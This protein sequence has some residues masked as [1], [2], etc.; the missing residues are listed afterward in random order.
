MTAV[1]PLGSTVARLCYKSSL[2][3]NGEITAS[4]FKL[5]LGSDQR[6]A[7]T[8]LSVHWLEYLGSG[9]LAAKLALLREYLLNSPIEGE[10][11]PPPTGRLAVLECDGAAVTIDAA[12]LATVEFQHVPRAPN[13]APGTAPDE[14]GSLVVGVDRAAASA[15]GLV[16]DPH[17]GLFTVPTEAAHE[18]AFQDLLAAAVV[19]SEPGRL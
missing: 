10:R 15:A 11:R 9:D 6:P 13:V 8:Y 3:S 2:G 7:D 16:L 18:L 14:S 12:K 17:S 19:Y 5:H 4:C 1:L